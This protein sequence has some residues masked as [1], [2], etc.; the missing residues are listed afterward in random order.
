MITWKQEGST[1][2]GY[3]GEKKVFEI[4]PSLFERN[5]VYAVLR[6]DTTPIYINSCFRIPEAKQAA[7]DFANE[8][9]NLF[10]GR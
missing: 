1:T 10:N 9:K 6:D 5:N 4:T 2:V 3:I 8:M 7:E